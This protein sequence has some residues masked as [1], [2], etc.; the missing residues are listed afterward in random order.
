M[1]GGITTLMRNIAATVA[2]GSDFE[3]K[4]FKATY[5]MDMEEPKEKHVS[6]IIECFA[7][8]HKAVVS[9]DNALLIFVE[10]HKNKQGDFVTNTKCFTILHRC[11]SNK[12]ICKLISHFIKLDENGNRFLKSFDPKMNEMALPQNAAPT[13]TKYE[14][15][16]QEHFS[17]QY[18]QYIK[19]W[20]KGH[21]DLPLVALSLLEADQATKDL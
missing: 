14:Q 19:T 1:K 9:Q 6:F 5:H 7:D 20:A 2:T 3:K 12:H 17:S 10:R 11:L 18:G 4:L 8:Q 13:G 15:A 16:F 21:T